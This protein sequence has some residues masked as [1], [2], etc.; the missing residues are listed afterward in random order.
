MG[1]KKKGLGKEK[2]PKR[3]ERLERDGGERKRER[4]RGAHTHTHTRR[5]RQTE[6]MEDDDEHKWDMQREG[7]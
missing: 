7:P 3:I 1:I 5:E 6:E 4:G 2:N